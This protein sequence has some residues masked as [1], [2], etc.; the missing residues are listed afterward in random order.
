VRFDLREAAINTGIET[1][2]WAMD[3]VSLPTDTRL[4]PIRRCLASSPQTTTCSRSRPSAQVR[5]TDTAVTEAR[6]RSC[7]SVPVV[8]QSTQSHQGSYRV[9]TL[10]AVDERGQT[11]RSFDIELDLTWLTV[12]HRSVDPIPRSRYGSAGP[13]GAD[14]RLAASANRDDFFIRLPPFTMCPTQY[15]EWGRRSMREE[16]LAPDRPGR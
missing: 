2:R 16:H 11:S 4:T 3:R 7:N 6:M 8:S 1:R 13:M 9:R 5:Y 10:W 14:G 15:R 12:S